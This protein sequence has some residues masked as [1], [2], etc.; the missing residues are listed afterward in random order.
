MSRTTIARRPLVAAAFGAAILVTA[1]CS[2]DNS[3]AAPAGRAESVAGF[4]GQEGV[5][6]Q[7]GTPIR[8]GNGRARTYVILDQKA[9]GRPLEVG[10]ALDGDAL[11]GLRGPAPMPPGEH[12]PH[13]HVDSD[14]FFLSMPQQHG[15][16]LKFLELNWNPAGHELNGVYDVPHFDF[17]FYAVS[18]AE[19]DAILP[20]DPEAQAKANHSPGPQFIPAFYM[21]GAP[22]GADVPWVPQ[23]GVHWIDVRSPE[24]QKAL[25]FGNPELWKPFTTTFIQG[26]WNG[27]VT[28]WEPMIT[29]AHI[30]S[31]RAATDAAGRDE[32]IPLGRPARY[33]E[34][35][36]YPGAYRIMWDA[37]AKEYRIALTQLAWGE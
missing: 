35:G 28:F 23:M 21:N 33:Q 14:A 2:D 19:R 3:P 4:E 8:L 5:H 1:G 25:P 37:Q 6:R 18:K 13:E 26:S 30:L 11:E 10:V 20:S 24:L 29:R 7:Y 27:K 9:G 32:V 15:T 34:P 31:K 16:P 22:P 17:H 36:Y 12:G